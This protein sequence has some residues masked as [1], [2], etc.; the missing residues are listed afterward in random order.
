MI[1][2]VFDSAKSASQA[3]AAMFASAILRKPDAVLGLATGS[4]PI[5]TYRQLAKWHK[6]GMLD[7]SRCTSFNLDEYVGLGPDHPCGY[8]YFMQ[9]NLFDHINMKETHV[10]DGL[11][12]NLK[13]ETRRYD[14]LIEK[15]GASIFSFSA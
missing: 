15:A 12:K 6:E 5:E 2:H 13:A 14:R 7:F 1:V 8:R 11:A 4:T 3:A 10:P 9:D